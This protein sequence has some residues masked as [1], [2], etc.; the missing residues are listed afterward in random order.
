MTSGRRV[1]IFVFI[2]HGMSCRI[3]K[4]CLPT[5]CLS[6]STSSTGFCCHF[7]PLLFPLFAVSSCLLVKSTDVS[8]TESHRLFSELLPIVSGSVFSPLHRKNSF[9]KQWPVP[10]LAC[11][12]QELGPRA[13]RQV[14]WTPQSL[15]CSHP[16][17]P[18]AVFSHSV[19]SFP[20]HHSKQGQLMRPSLS[21]LQTPSSFSSLPLLVCPR[22]ESLLF[23]FSVSPLSRPRGFYTVFMLLT[24]K[25]TFT[26]EARD[27]SPC[28][29]SGGL[30]N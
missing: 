21:A 2:H 16:L 22:L 28:G 23:F 25:P 10:V 8:L 14:L 1:T 15:L 26:A 4:A 11:A 3:G 27:P 13:A 5:P 7:V 20:S 12:R 29:Y 19:G 9:S 30:L 24:S 6:S 17:F 18:I